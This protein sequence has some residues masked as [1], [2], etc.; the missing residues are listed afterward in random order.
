MYILTI[1][2]P[3]TVSISASVHTRAYIFPIP[4]PQI[5]NIQS[6]VQKNMLDMDKMCV[7]MNNGICTV[8]IPKKEQEEQ[9]QQEQQ[10]Q[11]PQQL[12][13]KN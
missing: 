8:C 2:Y 13:R 11:Q 10:R 12:R 7:D 5:S 6:Q 9:Q 1:E 3:S 4:Y